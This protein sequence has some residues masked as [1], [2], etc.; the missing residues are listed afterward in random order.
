MFADLATAW[1]AT[2]REGERAPQRPSQS[3]EQLERAQTFGRSIRRHFSQFCLFPDL[4]PTR[5]IPPWSMM[6]RERA[7]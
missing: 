1:Q 2:W 6:R 5:L 3:E 7:V 4:P